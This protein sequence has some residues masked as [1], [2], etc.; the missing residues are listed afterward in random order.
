MRKLPTVVDQSE[1]LRYVVLSKSRKDV[2]HIVDL[3][4]GE[5]G[6]C[7]CE[8]WQFRNKDHPGMCIHLIAAHVHNDLKMV[9]L[10]K[11]EIKHAKKKT[12]R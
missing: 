10:I 4:Q 5:T 6:E 12:K 9:R 11:Q 2:A 3:E 7:S 8:D 1:R